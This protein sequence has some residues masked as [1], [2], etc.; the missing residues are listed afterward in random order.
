M[1]NWQPTT[2][3]A[4]I[5][6]Y[7][8]KL[9]KFATELIR[10][11]LSSSL[12]AALGNALL[13][14][15]KHLLQLHVD[16]NEILIDKSKIDRAKS[17]VKVITEVRQLKG[18]TQAICVGVDSKIDEK[19]LDYFNLAFMDFITATNLLWP[20]SLAENCILCLHSKAPTLKHT[21]QFCN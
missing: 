4:S 15:I 8:I 6:Y 12:G 14:G 1:A 19:T 13:F 11:D 16:I 18:K 2:S 7:I 5:P 20:K 17:K 9:N 3:A 21:I 10:G